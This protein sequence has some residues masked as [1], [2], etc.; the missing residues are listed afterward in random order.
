MHHPLLNPLREK[1]C[2]IVPSLLELK[3]GCKILCQDFEMNRDV[4]RTY[5]GTKYNV[6]ADRHIPQVFEPSDSK[7][8]PIDNNYKILGQEP[9][10]ADVLLAHLNIKNYNPQR[11]FVEERNEILKLWIYKHDSLSS[12]SPETIEFIGELLNVK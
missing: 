10:L 4:V 1:I 11:N 7:L 8:Y 2:E 12:Q 9:R 3:F 5:A 6:Q